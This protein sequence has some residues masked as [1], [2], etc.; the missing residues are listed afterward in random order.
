MPNEIVLGLITACTSLFGAGLGVFTSNRLINYRLE[1]L[2]KKVDKLSDNDQRLALLE[3]R[4]YAYE[5]ETKD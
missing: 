5:K 4:V 1:Q 2:E 3:Q